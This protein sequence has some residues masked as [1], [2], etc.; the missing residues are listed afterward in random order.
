MMNRY[1]AFAGISIFLVVFIYYANFS[2]R[3]GLPIS[4][5]VSNWASLGDYMGGVLGPVLNFITIFILVKS[6]VFQRH[7]NEKIREEIENNRKVE[8]LRSFESLF[9]NMIESQSK[10]FDSLFIEVEIDGKLIVKKDAEAAL[11]IEENIESLR[12][13]GISNQDINE[14]LED[15]DSF[16][17]FF[18]LLRS[19]YITVRMIAE[20]LSND[21]GFSSKDR[22]EHYLTL[23]N[24]TSFTHVRLVILMVQFLDCYPSKY[25]KEN[26]EFKEVLAK[27][28]VSLELY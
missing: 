16:D 2:L 14:Y 25:L 28:G 12:A 7:A 18:G 3:L 4:S 17:K 21:E 9:F 11:L 23:I 8:K 27:I 13:E 1:V 10:I 24:F 6:L 15:V 5:N 26:K 22:E 19:F 20:K